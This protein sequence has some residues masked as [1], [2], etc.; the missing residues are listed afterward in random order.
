MNREDVLTKFKTIWF[1]VSQIGIF[2]FG[3]IVVFLVPPPVEHY[4]AEV[5]RFLTIII[6]SFLLVPIF[7]Y[8]KYKFIKIWFIISIL[9][10]VISTVLFIFYQQMSA[11]F[12]VD[13]A[14]TRIVIGKSITESAK[15]K[16]H[17]LPDSNASDILNGSS[18]SNILLLQYA[19]GNA[20][21]IWDY[22][23][24]SRIKTWLIILFYVTI[25]FFTI[26]L[27]C[28]IQT[29]LILFSKKEF[30]QSSG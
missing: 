21:N 20:E 1:Q 5:P 6:T 28:I 30:G 19:R 2:I 16:I 27:V 15:K 3:I 18:Y 9:C 26:L 7:L 10:F 11:R 22:K 17:D 23:E 8:R 14:D 4:N 29:L 25:F 13:Y 12:I 24:I